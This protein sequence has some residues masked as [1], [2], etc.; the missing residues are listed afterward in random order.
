MAQ[1]ARV[2]APYRRLRDA[3]RCDTMLSIPSW[4]AIFQWHRSHFKLY[5]TRQ[6]I[7]ARVHFAVL[8]VCASPAVLQ[9]SRLSIS[10]LFDL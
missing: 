1:I 2:E 10:V 7:A 4:S 6:A 9:Q 8:A 5:T 3:M